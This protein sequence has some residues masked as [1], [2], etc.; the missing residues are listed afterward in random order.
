M[1]FIELGLRTYFILKRDRFLTTA[2]FTGSAST[3][4]NSLKI[5][6]QSLSLTGTGAEGNQQGYEIFLMRFAGLRNFLDPLCWGMKQ[7]NEIRKRLQL[8]S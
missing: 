6:E 4:H 7:K 1:W 5:R 2:I 8:L 3:V